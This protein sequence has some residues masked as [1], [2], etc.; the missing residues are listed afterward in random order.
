[1]ECD[2]GDK[3][4]IAKRRGADQSPGAEIA[5]AEC[6]GVELSPGAELHATEQSPG[7]EQSPGDAGPVDKVPPEATAATTAAAA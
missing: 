5:M 2:E 1:M 4:T 7:A 3:L 6:P